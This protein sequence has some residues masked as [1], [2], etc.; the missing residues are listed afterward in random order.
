MIISRIIRESYQN[1]K[2]SSNTNRNCFYL[3]KNLDPLHIDKD[4]N[5]S[6][7]FVFHLFYSNI[8]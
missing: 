1:K 6:F 2:N 8:S 5:G 7:Q 4:S 3:V